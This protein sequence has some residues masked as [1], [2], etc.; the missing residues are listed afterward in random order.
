MFLSLQCLGLIT[1][2]GLAVGYG[3]YGIVECPNQGMFWDKET[4][5]LDA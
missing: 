3:N 1:A 5:F 4:M 2:L